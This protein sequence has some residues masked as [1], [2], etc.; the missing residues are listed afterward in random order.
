[1]EPNWLIWARELQ[2]IAQTGLS[3]ATDAFDRQR[4]E[5]IRA[6]AARIMAE[7]AGLDPVRV[8]A[9]FAAEEGH[10][11]PKVGV[12]GAVF[13]GDGAILLVREASDGRWSL[14]GGWAEVDQSPSESVAREIREESGFEVAVHK[15]AAVYDQARQPQPP[16]HPFHIY[17]LFFIC[18]IIAG[19]ARTS[20]ETTE[21]GFFAENAIPPDLSPARTRPEHLARMFAHYRSPELPTDFD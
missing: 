14:P 16:L 3:Y 6:V 4:Y 9:L 11:T 5:A 8:E 13:R 20:I 2:A 15:L 21:V 7:A 19:N 17:R 1:M 10:A 12:R 18:E